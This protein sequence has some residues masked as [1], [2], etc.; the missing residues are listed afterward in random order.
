[1]PLLARFTRHNP[2]L[3]WLQ[4]HGW[5]QGATFPGVW[6]ALRNMQE[7]GKKYG[8]EQVSYAQQDHRKDLLD[9][10]FQASK[11]H[12]NFVQQK[13]ILSLSL[14]MIIAGAETT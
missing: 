11:E 2:V 5:T 13:E 7:R 6:L 1:M 8:T 12:P 3:L 10:F 14:T 9:K 4:R